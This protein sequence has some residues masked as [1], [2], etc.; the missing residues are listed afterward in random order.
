MSL[1]EVYI[2]AVR[3]LVVEANSPL[4]DSGVDV[5]D[6]RITD[7]TKTFGLRHF[8]DLNTVEE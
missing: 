5:Y 3:E 2:K 8:Q 6:I 7:K 1:L 4:Y